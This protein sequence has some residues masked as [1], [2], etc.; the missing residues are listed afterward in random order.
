MNDLR[1]GYV[2]LFWYMAHEL[3]NHIHELM[4]YTPIMFMYFLSH[5][6]LLD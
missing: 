6:T 5:S 4:T 2:G 1:Y 3:Q